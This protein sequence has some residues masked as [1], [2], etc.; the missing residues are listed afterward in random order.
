[1]GLVC[2]R[3]WP[4]CDS[5]A[6]PRLTPNLDQG[7]EQAVLRVRRVTGS[8]VEVLTRSLSPQHSGDPPRSL[9]Q[10]SPVVTRG[11]DDRGGGPGTET[12]SRV[13]QGGGPSL[14]SPAV[15]SHGGDLSVGPRETD[16]EPDTISAE[17]GT[18]RV[19]T[20]RTGGATTHPKPT[21]TRPLVSRRRTTPLGRSFCPH[22]KTPESS[23]RGERTT[24]AQRPGRTRTPTPRVD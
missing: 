1:M 9:S 8:S 23:R 24:F 7:H 14:P 5:S 16:S 3:L 13:D 6:A 15:V 11:R 18:R 12:E 4:S 19:P 20:R 21:R 2:R 17:T 22:R 10:P